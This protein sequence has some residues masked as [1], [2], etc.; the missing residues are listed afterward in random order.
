M[1]GS[2]SRAQNG[3]RTHATVPEL[4][5]TE[6][7]LRGRG[8]EEEEEEEEEERERERERDWTPRSN[9][10]RKVPE[11]MEQVLSGTHAPSS[12]MLQDSSTTKVFQPLLHLF[13]QLI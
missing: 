9:I 5:I 10:G 11:T 13:F 8:E 3:G 4:Q 2:K 1:L 12:E 6:F 7:F